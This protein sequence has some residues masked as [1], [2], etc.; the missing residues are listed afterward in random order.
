MLSWS[1]GDNEIRNMDIRKGDIYRLHPGSVFYIQ[2]SLEPERER[3]RIYS[4]FS[5]TDQDIYDPSVGAYSS[6]NDLLFGFDPKVL[7]AAFKVPED[8]IMEMMQAT[9]PPAIVHAVSEKKKNLCHWQARLL[10]AFLGSNRDSFE[11]F[12]GKKKLKP[13]NILEAKPDFE[14][15]NGWSLTVDKHPSRLLKDTNIG[16]FMVNLT[17][18]GFLS[19]PF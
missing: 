12:N 6:I 14:N 17:N 18:V 16:V 5:N 8:V 3:L 13:Y 2:R 9:K 1:D 19:F 7:Q 11:T 15:C 4:I 10:K